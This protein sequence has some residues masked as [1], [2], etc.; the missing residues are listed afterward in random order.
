MKVLKKEIERKKLMELMVSV[1]IVLAIFLALSYPISV[2]NA[3]IDI[4]LKFVSRIVKD[5][6]TFIISRRLSS[7]MLPLSF[8]SA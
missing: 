3:N 5:S 6:Y 2:P 8:H 7:L 1:N 4:L